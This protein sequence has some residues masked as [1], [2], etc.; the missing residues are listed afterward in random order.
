MNETLEQSRRCA[1]CGQYGRGAFPVNIYLPEGGTILACYKV[2][3][4]NCKR[5]ECFFTYGPGGREDFSCK[6][7]ILPER[8]S[9]EALKRAVESYPMRMGFYPGEIREYERDLL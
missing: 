1:N 4:V 9:F 7:V 2:M 5:I 6:C 3:C 8:I